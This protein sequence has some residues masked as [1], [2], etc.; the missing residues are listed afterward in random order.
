MTGGVGA[1]EAL[2]VT[3]LLAEIA[4]IG[5]DPVRGG[6]SRHVFDDGDR[7][8]REWFT[9][10]AT[11][12]GLDVVPDADGNLWAWWGTPGPDSVVT[13]SHLDSVPG[14]GAYDGPL[15]VASALAAVARLKARGHTPTRPLAV[16]V[17]AE[18]EGSRFGVACLG[19][20]LLT[21]AVDPDQARG[22]RD[23]A[24]TPLAEVWAANGLDPQRLGPDEQALGRIGCFVELHVE[25]GVDLVHRGVPVALATAILAHGR[26]CVR[27]VGQGNHAGATPMDARHDPVVVAAKSVLAAREAALARPGARA[28]VGRVSVVPGGTNV[29][30][31]VAE[32]YL[33]VRAADDET[34]RAVVAGITDVVRAAAEAEG[35]TVEVVEESFAPAVVFDAGLRDRLAAVLGGPPA[36][37]TGA[38]H[39]AGV[40]AAHVPTAMLFVRNPTGIS[41]APEESAAAEDCER[42]V[43]ALVR[44]LEELV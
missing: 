10:R 42:G 4:E 26:W 37:P 39:D 34:V 14:G 2:T 27:A 11:G 12:L 32:T 16:V 19:S 44:V 6:Y 36:I 20:G 21:G 3:G 30:A 33:D 43:D 29:I 13:G 17:F 22:L 31:S 28:T 5:R 7:A 24:G 1:H 25:Q 8:L 41:H 40:L 9:A 18:E 35:C 38:G 15:G 23:A